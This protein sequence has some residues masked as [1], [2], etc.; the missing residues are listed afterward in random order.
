METKNI[1]SHPL[2]E[3]LYL[4]RRFFAQPHTVGSIWPSSRF[5][6]R[7]MLRNVFLKKGDLVVEYGPGTG[8]FT[9]LLRPYLTHGVHYLGIERDG[10]L[11]KAIQTRF[12][13]MQFHHGS[14][15]ET[16]SLLERYQLPKASLIVSGLPFANMPPALQR[17]ILEAA[18]DSLKPEGEFRTFTYLF[19]SLNPRSIDF[20]KTAALFFQKKNNDEVV[21]LNVPPAK[22]MRFVKK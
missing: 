5:L 10:K 21:L 20:Q 1:H 7:A 13:E 3:R 4:M 22:V 9:S 2:R 12:P 6:G 11:Y 17:R 14:A 15:E 18:Y 8:P 19:S 16:P